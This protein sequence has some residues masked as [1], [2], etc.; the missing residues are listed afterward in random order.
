MFCLTKPPSRTFSRLCTTLP[1]RP[2]SCCGVF[3]GTT[4]S[5]GSTAIFRAEMAL[6]VATRWMIFKHFRPGNPSLLA[7]SL[8]LGR[9]KASLRLVAHLCAIPVVEKAACE[10][11]RE[12]AAGREDSCLDCSILPYVNLLLLPNVPST[13]ES[14]RSP[15]SFAPSFAMIF[16][17]IAGA[18]LF[19]FP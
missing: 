1:R 13:F 15:F 2:S 7:Y 5:G 18:A 11:Q 16:T 10:K 9:G 12:M 17:H 14:R 4:E 6:Q 8:F 19:F 3:Q